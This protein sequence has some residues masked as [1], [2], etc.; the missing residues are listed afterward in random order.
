MDDNTTVKAEFPI[1]DSGKTVVVSRPTDQQ[2]FLISLSRK[3]STPAESR[4]LIQRL[5]GVLE[6]LMGEEQWY[7]VVEYGL[8][9]SEFAPDDVF[10]LARDIMNFEWPTGTDN[11]SPDSAPATPERPAPRLVSGG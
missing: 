2:M 3:P 6:M 10:S 4:R 8:M 7:D 1:G 9:R 5:F 11:I